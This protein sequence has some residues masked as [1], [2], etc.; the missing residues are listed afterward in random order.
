[1]D[2]YQENVPR[3]TAREE[4]EYDGKFKRINATNETSPAQVRERICNSYKIDQFKYLECIRSGNKLIV[5][6]NQK[7]NGKDAILRRGCLYLCKEVSSM[8]KY[9]QK[10][11]FNWAS[12]W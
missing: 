3:G 8:H 1:M 5:S 11:T 6:S 2:K 7:M 10:V 9:K 12:L 4:I